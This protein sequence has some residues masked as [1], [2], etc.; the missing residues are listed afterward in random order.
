M[1]IFDDMGRF[2][3][4]RLDEFLKANPHLEL[5]ILEDKLREQELDTLR[6]LKELKNEEQA[7]QDTILSTAEEI[8][9]WHERIRKAQKAGR[10]DLASAA[11]EREAQLLR[12]GNQQWAHMEMAKTRITQTKEL[13]QQIQKRREEVK[14][15]MQSEPK[16]SS[17]PKSSPSSGWYKSP[18][19][20]SNDPLEEKFRQWEVEDDLNDLKRNMGR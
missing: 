13:Y 8:K 12:Q 17:P 18:P 5:Q 4:E 20:A 11:Q 16:T 9:R 6:L 19:K 10:Q 7:A 2:L 15:K 1:S 3:E 14:V